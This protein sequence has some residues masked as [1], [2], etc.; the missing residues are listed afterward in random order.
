[1]TVLHVVPAGQHIF[2][3]QTLPFS[4]VPQFRVPPQ[5]SEIVPHCR[6]RTGQVYGVQPQFDSAVT[7][8]LVPQAVPSE[9][10]EQTR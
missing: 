9:S 2:R 10:D 5:A 6:P 8:K 7:L 1:M 3:L 4:H